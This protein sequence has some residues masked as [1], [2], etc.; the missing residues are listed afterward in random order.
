MVI[1]LGLKG[2]NLYE[3]YGGGGCWWKVKPEQWNT[4]LFHN[5]SCNFSRRG[6][7]SLSKSNQC[8]NKH[9]V[10]WAHVPISKSRLLAIQS[11]YVKVQETYISRYMYTV[12]V[13]YT[14]Q[15]VSICKVHV[16]ANV[17]AQYVYIY[18]LYLYLWVLCFQSKDSQTTPGVGNQ[19]SSAF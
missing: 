10:F 8:G 1:F 7:G 13:H 16:H 3:V 15:Y 2:S 18:K 11:K 5:S 14:C 4:Y 17:H 6:A 12:H 9:D 19:K